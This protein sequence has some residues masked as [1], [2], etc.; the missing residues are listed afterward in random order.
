MIL[1]QSILQAA[2]NSA[3]LPKESFSLRTVFQVF[4]PVGLERAF[5]SVVARS[6]RVAA[7]RLRLLRTTPFQ[8]DLLSVMRP[9][10]RNRDDQ[11]KQHECSRSNDN[12]NKHDSIPSNWSRCRDCKA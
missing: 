5:S 3:L 6:C 12:G 7:G 11:E 4:H 10:S 8:I 9:I 2:R 1:A